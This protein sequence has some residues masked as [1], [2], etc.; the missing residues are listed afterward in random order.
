L[1]SLDGWNSIHD[2]RG[3]AVELKKLNLAERAAK[4]AA[5]KR[6]QRSA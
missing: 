4:L 6:I 2:D 3:E 1:E 5:F